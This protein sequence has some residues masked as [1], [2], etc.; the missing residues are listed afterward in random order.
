MFQAR[1]DGS[2]LRSARSPVCDVCDHATSR[3]TSS[4]RP[5]GGA[6]ASGSAAASGLLGRRHGS[7][8]VGPARPLVAQLGLDPARAHLGHPLAADVVAASLEHGEVE[9]HRQPQAG[10]DQRQVLVGQL[11]LQRLGRGGHDDL[12]PAQRGRDEIG[13]R[14]ARPGPRLDDEVASA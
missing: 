5:S 9:R 6:P 10:L 8:L 7:G 2:K 12:L 1:S 11:V 13:Q 14:L 3:R 4:T